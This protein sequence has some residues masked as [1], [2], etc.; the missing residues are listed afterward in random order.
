[1]TGRCAPFIVR[2]LKPDRHVGKVTLSE[3]VREKDKK[4]DVY[5]CRE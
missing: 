5:G 2:Q 4:C 3:G 1:V